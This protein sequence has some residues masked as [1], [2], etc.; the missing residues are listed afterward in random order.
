[1]HTA[2][3]TSTSLYQIVPPPS[4][5]QTG[6]ILLVKTLLAFGADMNHQGLNDFTP[7]D[8]AIHS[9]SSEVERVLLEHGAKGSA[10]LIIQ[11]Q[12]LSVVRRSHRDIMNPQFD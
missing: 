1:M 2:D 11:K 3:N 6:D 12:K 10:N 4:P 8:L 9:Q 7:L 5:L